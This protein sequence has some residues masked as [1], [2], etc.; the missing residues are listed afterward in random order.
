MEVIIIVGG[1][2]HKAHWREEYLGGP[3]FPSVQ[4]HLSTELNLKVYSPGLK[5][6]KVS[7]ANPFYLWFRKLWKK[8]ACK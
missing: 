4:N 5:C 6:W 1:M 7:S 3:W 2:L 8:T